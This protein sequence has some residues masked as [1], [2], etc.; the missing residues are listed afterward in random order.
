MPA[1]A[2]MTITAST[3]TITMKAQEEMG[4]L[5]RLLDHKDGDK[6]TSF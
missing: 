1:L 3:I 5:A 2:A 4:V 6:L